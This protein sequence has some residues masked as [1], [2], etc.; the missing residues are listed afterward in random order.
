[1][2]ALLTIGLIG[3]LTATVVAMHLHLTARRPEPVLVRPMDDI[4]A[5]FF[6][7]IS[8]ERLRDA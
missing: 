5:E 4:D 3:S 2:D 8:A 6:R 1:M 7:I